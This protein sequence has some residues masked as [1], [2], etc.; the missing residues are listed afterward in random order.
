MKSFLFCSPTHNTLH[1]KNQ[2]EE[3]LQ[4]VMK[5]YIHIYV[6]NCQGSIG[7][8]NCG[9]PWYWGQDLITNIHQTEV[10]GSDFFGTNE[11]IEKTEV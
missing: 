6:K 11:D 9:V 7:T 4:L 5:D 1:D 8:L 10:L 3:V 2:E